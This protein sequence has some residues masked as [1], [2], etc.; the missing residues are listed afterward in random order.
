MAPSA[1]RLVS[2]LITAGFSRIVVGIAS[3]RADDLGAADKS[4][5]QL[6]LDLQISPPQMT[7]RRE[8]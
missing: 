7:I 1:L 6:L 2:S 3:P 5:R 4:Y 8:L